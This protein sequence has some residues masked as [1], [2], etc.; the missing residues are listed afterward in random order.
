MPENGR[1]R[2][3]HNGRKTFLQHH[4][5]EMLRPETGTRLQEIYMVGQM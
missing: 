4:S 2:R 3:R 5:N 1:L